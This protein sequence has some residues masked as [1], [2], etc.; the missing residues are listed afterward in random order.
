[1]SETP[2]AP[3]S[4]GGVRATARTPGRKEASLS[5]DIDAR[6]TRLLDQLMRPGL[7]ATEIDRINRKIEVLED[8]KVMQT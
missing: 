6:I 2:S 4:G 7:S 3:A 5:D 1:M 8:R